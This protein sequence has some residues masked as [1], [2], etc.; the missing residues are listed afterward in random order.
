MPG[1]GCWGVTLLEYLAA[2]HRLH[3]RGWDF[4]AVVLVVFLSLLVGPCLGACVVLTGW[5]LIYTQSRLRGL[6]IPA[7]SFG[8]R[9]LFAPL[10]HFLWTSE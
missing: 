7:T 8:W 2:I 9:R 3:C 1:N 4:G 10:A 5:K 6:H